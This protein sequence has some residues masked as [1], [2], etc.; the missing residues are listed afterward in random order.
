MYFLRQYLKGVKGS[1]TKDIWSGDFVPTENEILETFGDN[2]KYIVFQRGK[3]IRG[4]KKIVEYGPYTPNLMME[5]ETPK[6]RMMSG[7]KI[8]A[9]SDWMPKVFAAEGKTINVK[10]QIDL[11]D[12]SDDDLDEL[13]GSMLNTPVESE[14]D[15][16]KFSEDTQKIRKEINRRLGERQ[17]LVSSMQADMGD[18][19]DMVAENDTISKALEDAQKL[20]GEGHSTL[21]VVMAGVTG[22]VV[23]GVAQEVRWSKKMTEAEERLARLESQLSDLAESQEK[24]AEQRAYDP[25]ST[26]NILHRF[27]SSQGL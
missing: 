21:A 15:F 7:L 25:L 19:D 12:L 27:N 8:K 13:W 3:G 4:M 1:G 23:G 24:R 16:D 14:D 5:D 18:M 26:S 20:V 17:S 9:K 2:G 22:L 6:N 10:Q 11:E